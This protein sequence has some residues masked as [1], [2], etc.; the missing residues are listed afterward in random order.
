MSIT[1][2]IFGIL[3]IWTLAV[4]SPGADTFMIINLII[5]YGK[6]SAI[7]GVLGIVAGTIIWLI[8]GFFFVSIL[9]DTIFFTILQILGGGY[10]IFLGFNALKNLKKAQ[11]IKEQMQIKASKKAFFLGLFTNLS[12]P[13]AP[14]FISII[15][16]K[17]DPN[18]PQIALALLFILMICIAFLWF[19]FVV[20][21][22]SIKAIFDKFISHVKKFDLASGLIFLFFGIS[23]VFDGVKN[24]Y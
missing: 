23:L 17:L 15:L 3:L 6:K 2:D 13:K 24:V 9:K 7:S 5:K 19:Y 18:S 12:N 10:L 8:V 21:F 4:M 14:L 16:S 1:T 22:L 20:N 11:N